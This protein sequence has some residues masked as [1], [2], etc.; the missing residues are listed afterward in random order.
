MAT[1]FNTQLRSFICPFAHPAAVGVDIMATDLN[2]WSSVYLFPPIKM[3]LRVLWKLKSY[4][5][6]GVI[7]VPR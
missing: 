7:I 4:R 5:G 2:R 1:P 6:K 3:I